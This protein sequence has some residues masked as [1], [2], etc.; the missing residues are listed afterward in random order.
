MGSSII[1]CVISTF[2]LTLEKSCDLTPKSLDLLNVQA[3][4]SSTT[5]KK[6]VGNALT[7]SESHIGD[8]VS[9]IKSF[10]SV[11]QQT[12]PPWSEFIC[13]CIFIYNIIYHMGS[14]SFVLSGES[15]LLV[16]T[17]QVNS[18]FRARWLA[19]S[20]VIS[21]YYS[22][23]SSRRETKCFS[24]RWS[25][26]RVNYFE[27]QGGCSIKYKKMTTKFGLTAFNG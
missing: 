14:V 5:K 4:M 21:Q 1:S 7:N 23:P 15:N 13:Y 19:S 18:V 24:F 20:E 22:P 16:Y 17:T 11:N 9:I 2:R 27:K 26:Q 3:Q 10:L 6:I 25:Y 8:C 12:C